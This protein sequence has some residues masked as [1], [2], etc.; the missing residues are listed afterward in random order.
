[1]KEKTLIEM[2]NKIESFLDDSDT[3]AL[4]KLMEIYHEMIR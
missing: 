3:I 4:N 2:K 1:M